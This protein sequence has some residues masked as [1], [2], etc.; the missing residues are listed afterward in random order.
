MGPGRIGPLLLPRLH[1]PSVPTIRDFIDRQSRLALTSREAC[2]ADDEPPPG[3]RANRARIRLGQGA[4][5]F[6]AGKSA[7]R[8]WEQFPREWV[9]LCFPD[10]PIEPGRVVAVLAR[11]LGVWWL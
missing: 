5:A 4:A 9:E 3:Y 6:A 8:G 1:R 2:T 11:G 10:V 7:L